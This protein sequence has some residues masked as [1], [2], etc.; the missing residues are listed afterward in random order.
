MKIEGLVQIIFCGNQYYATNAYLGL[1]RNIPLI[2]CKIERGGKEMWEH[3]KSTIR[4]KA[5]LLC[6]Y[7]SKYHLI[8]VFFLCVCCCFS[9]VCVNLLQRCYRCFFHQYVTVISVLFFNHYSLWPFLPHCYILTCSTYV[10]SFLNVTHLYKRKLKKR[11]KN[12]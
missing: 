7:K 10:L 2:E 11:K 1:N 5:H 8:L 9:R 3:P 4:F 6:R 12:V